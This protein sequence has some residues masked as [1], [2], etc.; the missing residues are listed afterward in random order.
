M[1][2]TKFLKLQSDKQCMYSKVLPHLRWFII[3]S[4][5]IF[6]L[7]GLGTAFATSYVVVAMV[8]NGSG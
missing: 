1:K 2:W 7:S 5:L 3:Y 8:N 4:L 6:S